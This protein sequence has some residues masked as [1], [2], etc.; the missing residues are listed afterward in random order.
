M[1]AGCAFNPSRRRLLQRHLRPYRISPEKRKSRYL[2]AAC[3]PMRNSMKD[4]R[5]GAGAE[6]LDLALT[7]GINEGHVR[8]SATSHSP[9][10]SAEDRP[11]THA[12]CVGRM[13]VQAGFLTRG[14]LPC[15]AFPGLYPVASWKKARRLQLRGQFRVRQPTW[16]AAPDSLCRSRNGNGAPT[17]CH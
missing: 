12:P 13:T 10:T 16:P 8:S 11:E 4:C 5:G 15:S 9:V 17:H 6:G 1:T 2:D 3:G 7:A 14:S